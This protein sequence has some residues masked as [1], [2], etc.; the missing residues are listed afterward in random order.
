MA[1][2]KGIASPYGDDAPNAHWTVRSISEDYDREEVG[3][4]VVVHVNKAAR[5]AGKEPIATM[6]FTLV[7]ADYAAFKAIPGG[8]RQS[9]YTWLVANRPELEGAV[10]D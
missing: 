2:R 5:N 8:M 9:A 4:V 1:L 7:G 3:I 6:A 10:E